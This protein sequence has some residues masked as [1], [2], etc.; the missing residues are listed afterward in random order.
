MFKMLSYCFDGIE[1]NLKAK[2]ISKILIINFS[3]IRNK[4]KIAYYLSHTLLC[5]LFLFLIIL[6]II[7]FVYFLI[8][9]L[10]LFPIFIWILV[11]SQVNLIGE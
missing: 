1:L 7:E 10:L 5:L 9:F 4:L 6:I 3:K 11:G 2:Y 8:I